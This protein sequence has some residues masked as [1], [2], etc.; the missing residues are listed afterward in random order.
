MKTKKLVKTFPY[1]K[2]Q[3]KSEDINDKTTDSKPVGL[4]VNGTE[5]LSP[6]LFDENY[7]YGRIE[8]IIVTNSGSNYDVLDPPPVEVK[9][10]FGSGCKAHAN[11]SGGL[12]RVKIISPGVGYQS[13][14]K[15]KISGGNGSGAV[16]ESNLVSSRISVGF[17]GDTGVSVADNTLTTIDDVLFVNGEEVIY[18]TN[19]NTDVLGIVN[20]SSYFVGI[21]TDKKVKPYNNKQD[22]VA[23]NNEIQIT[24]IS[25]G[26]H[27]LESLKNKNTITEIYVNDPGDG[28]S[29]RAIKVPSVVSSDNRTLGVN[30]F[31]SY[32]Y[33]TNHGFQNSEFVVYE[34]TDTEIS[35]LDTGKYYQVTKIDDNKF[36]L[37]DAGTASSTTDYNY[38]NRK[39]V[40]FESLGVGTHTIKYPP[41]TISIESTSELESIPVITP[42]VK[43]IVLGQID[44]VFVE[45]G[46]VG[47]GVTDII[48]FHRRPN[49]GVGSILSNAVLKSF[50]IINGSITD[51]KI[52][53]RGKGYRVDSDIIVQSLSDFAQLDPVVDSEGKLQSINIVNG[54]IGYASST[55]FLSI[56]NRA[57]MPSL[58]LISRGGK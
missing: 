50:I 14:P 47:Y 36:R 35:G 28:Y 45:D 57:L 22:A 15:I 34:Y 4:L 11:L 2:V 24:G 1:S 6:T 13:K 41:I 27:A 43:P 48:N 52:I 26:F 49:V 7:Y 20:G 46:G 55:T 53:N 58:L 25:S 40:K 17:K 23:G 44:D 31:D 19:D 39:Y 8:E 12:T 9:D 42:V 32:I 54:G 33:A 5:I 16:L 10:E 18:S 29:N 21:V 56:Q 51:V 30:T 38:I 37:S 3:K